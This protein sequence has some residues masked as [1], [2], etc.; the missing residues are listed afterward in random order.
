MANNQSGNGRNVALPDENRPSWRP[1]DQNLRTRGT[2]EGRYR[3]DR[4]VDRYAGDRHDRGRPRESRMG[5]HWE[6]DRDESM[7]GRSDWSMTDRYGQG[8]SG[9]GF[10]RYGEDRAMGYQPRS[11]PYPSQYDREGGLDER[12]SGRGYWQDRGERIDRGYNPERLGGRGFEDRM[13]SQQHTGYGYS[14]QHTGYG[15]PGGQGQIVHP[16]PR[17]GHRGKGPQGYIRSDERIRELVCEALTDDDQIDATLIEVAVKNSEVIL[18]G[19]V[20]DRQTKR[21]AEDVAERI[22]GVRDVHNQIR[23]QGDQRE[24][25]NR[26]NPVSSGTVGRETETTDKKHRA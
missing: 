3:D 17:Y 4:D 8:Q 9:Y 25:Q 21:A 14:Q 16:H 12:F 2:D 19:T 7:R 10:G 5:G 6:D 20:D 18:S 26:G 24:S 23:V 1:Q 11:Q 22:R 13:G 15:N